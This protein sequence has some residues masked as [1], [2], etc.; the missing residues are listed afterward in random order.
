MADLEELFGR[1]VAQGD[2]L[3]EAVALVV[4]EEG[5]LAGGIQRGVLDDGVA[6]HGLGEA[7]EFGRG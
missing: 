1:G 4:G 3:D 7:G 6:Q 5:G 2:G